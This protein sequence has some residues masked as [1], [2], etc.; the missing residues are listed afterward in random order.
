[1][2]R[3]AWVVGRLARALPSLRDLFRLLRLTQD[4]RPGLSYAVAPR[5]GVGW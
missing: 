3:V 5:L 1:V 4:L 2:V